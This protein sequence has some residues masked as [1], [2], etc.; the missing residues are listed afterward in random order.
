MNDAKHLPTAL[1]ADDVSKLHDTGPGHPEC[2]ARF[3]AV[4]VKIEQTDDTESLLHLKPRPA[5]AKE[6]KA[7]H[8]PDYIDVA[9][10]DIAA[11]LEMLSTGDTT[12]CR[13]SLAPA[14]HAAGGV[15][16]A[17]DTVLTGKAKNAFCVHRPPGHHA[18]P[19]TG[20][21]F[22]IFNNAAIAAR[23]AQSKYGIAKVLIV[24]WDVHHGNGTQDI[25]YDDPTVFF[26][27]THQ[28]PWYP[29]T[30]DKEE[31]GHGKGLG[32]TMNRPF[33]AGAG[34]KEIVGAFENDLAPAVDRFKPEL[35]I[36]S[37]GF[38]SRIDDPLGQFQLTDD[39]FTELTALMLRLAAEHAE[40]R[41]VSVLEGGYNLDGLA[42]ASAAH[43]GRLVEG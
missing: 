1:I 41:V 34:R 37:A 24:D 35:V 18:T 2:I 42:S 39:D 22:C 9:Q 17:V 6:I 26:F 16:I 3:D 15:C 13:K 7:C 4:M 5:T 30:G 10:R 11:G 23:Y 8:H 20:M 19:D 38:D 12:V 32:M 27:S 21:G 43:C 31:T 36:I 14:L 40:G 33:P 29:G 25:F 28:S